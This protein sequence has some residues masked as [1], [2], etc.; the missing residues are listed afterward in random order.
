MSESDKAHGVTAEDL[1]TLE[2]FEMA[3]DIAA[4]DA[5]M[6]ADDG[7]RISIADLRREIATGE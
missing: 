2:N 1:E 7:E 5:A 6:A 3:L 4:Y